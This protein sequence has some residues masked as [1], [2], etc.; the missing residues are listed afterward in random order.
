MKKKGGSLGKGEGGK[1]KRRKGVGKIT[2]RVSKKATRNYY[3]NHLP[4]KNNY[5]ACDSVNK[6]MYS[7]N[8]PFSS[9]LTILPPRAKDHLIKPPTPDMRGPLWF[10]SQDFRR[11]PQNIQPT[12]VLATLG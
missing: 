7:F 2:I 9:R 3:R 4:K 12:D 10:V 5:N 11:Q 6:G 1:Y 8:E